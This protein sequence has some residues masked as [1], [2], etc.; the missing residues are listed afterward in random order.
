MLGVVLNGKKNYHIFLLEQD[1]KNLS[2]II[3][4]K[5]SQL[6]LMIS[7]LDITIFQNAT[8][9]QNRG[10]RI[11]VLTCLTKLTMTLHKGA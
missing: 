11:F 9:T 1:K 5:P 3:I 6:L 7:G 10:V 8:Q 4:Y 2:E